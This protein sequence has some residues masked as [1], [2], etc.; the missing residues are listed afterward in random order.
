MPMRLRDEYSETIADR[1][2][3][4]E[5]S[6]TVPQR[7]FGHAILKK[8][9]FAQNSFNKGGYQLFFVQLA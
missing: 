1:K 2:K 8:I 5:T 6:I 4:H 3:I 9:C 7:V